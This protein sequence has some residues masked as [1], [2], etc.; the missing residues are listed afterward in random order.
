MANKPSQLFCQVGECIAIVRRREGE[1]KFWR[2]IKPLEFHFFLNFPAKILK[3]N[4]VVWMKFMGGL[5]TG[6]IV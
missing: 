3:I 5:M 4:V 1:K 2:E 6:L